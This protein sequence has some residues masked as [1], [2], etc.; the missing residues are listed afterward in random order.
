MGY[1]PT[2]RQMMGAAH[3]S[4]YFPWLCSS[5]A[6][7]PWLVEQIEEKPELLRG[8]TADFVSF[9]AALAQKHAEKT[10]TM[11]DPFWSAHAEGRHK[12]M[13]GGII[14]KQHAPLSPTTPYFQAIPTFA[15]RARGQLKAARG[16]DFI[17][18]IACLGGGVSTPCYCRTHASDPCTG[19]F[20][21]V[22]QHT[23]LAEHV[24]HVAEILAPVVYRALQVIP[25]KS[26]DPPTGREART[27][28]RDMVPAELSPAQCLLVAAAA[29]DFGPKLFPRCIPEHAVLVD[30][31]ERV[32]AKLLPAGHRGTEKPTEVTETEMRGI[33]AAFDRCPLQIDNQT[34]KVRCAAGYNYMDKGRG[35]LLWGYVTNR[36]ICT[37]LS[38]G[39]FT[40]AGALQQCSSKGAEV[41]D[42]LQYFGLT[43]A[44]SFN[45]MQEHLR[46]ATSSRAARLAQAKGEPADHGGP[47]W[48]I[49][50]PCVLIHCCEVKQ[51]LNA[52]GRDS[53]EH[54]IF[55]RSAD[56]KMLQ[57]LL[58]G[59]SGHA[60]PF[61]L[62]LVKHAMNSHQRLS[63][64]TPRAHTNYTEKSAKR[65]KRTD[66]R[67]TTVTKHK[68]ASGIPLP[69]APQAGH[70]CDS[71]AEATELPRHMRCQCSG[72]CAVGSPMC[73][74]RQRWSQPG[75]TGGKC[76][77]PAVIVSP[78]ALRH[79]CTSC[80]CRAQGCSHPRR[81]GLF[82]GRH[83]KDHTKP[84]DA[85]LGWQPF[86][87]APQWGVQTQPVPPEKNT[88]GKSW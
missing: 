33:M 18:V 39:M 61:M 29:G 83:H 52:L 69:A 20:M 85:F 49:Y 27:K 17:G 71:Q 79:Y 75:H 80:L 38:P 59:H 28:H 5:V 72:M 46:Q 42:A 67:R 19:A 55:N 16:D 1:P 25:R 32:I 65:Q 9:A 26:P 12:F 15:S 40:V 76:P 10:S 63:R 43:S 54:A 53:V 51:T 22:L 37:H 36:L 6:G 82:C 86:T 81:R 30:G 60:H 78:D 24:D 88:A 68:P 7:V 41:K 56:K 70:G 57:Q 47:A 62:V 34:S 73:L 66:H 11:P 87:G 2:P 4:I 45:T 50:W 64:K 58:Q 48:Q 8:S 23:E 21:A 74:A 77:N 14:C 84:N 31:L 35:F 44:A 3:G 13:S